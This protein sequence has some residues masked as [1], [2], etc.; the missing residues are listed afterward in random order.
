M[1]GFPLLLTSG[2]DHW[3]PVQTCSG[4]VPWEHHLV[5]ATETEASTASKEVV[6]ILLACFLVRHICHHGDEATDKLFSDRE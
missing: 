6:C 2:D 1:V 5:V 4:R 3:R